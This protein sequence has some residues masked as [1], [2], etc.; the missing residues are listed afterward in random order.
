MLRK[1]RTAFSRGV[2]ALA[3]AVVVVASAVP[4]P[5]ADAQ[6]VYCTNCS[7]RVTQLLQHAQ[8]A[9]QIT[10]QVDQLRM[11][12][13][14]YDQMARDVVNLPDTV[15]SGI[16]Q[17]IGRVHSAIEQGR[18]LAYTVKNLDDQIASRYGSLD[19]YMRTDMSDGQM[20]SKYAQ[21]DAERADGVKATYRA[22]GLQ[23]EGMVDEQAFMDRLRQRSRT[24]QG[25][26]EVAT[27]GHEL[28]LEGIAQMQRLRQ[29]IMLQVGQQ[30][31]D[32]QLRQDLEAVS[33]ARDQQ[34]NTLPN[35]SYNAKTY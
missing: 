2:S 33:A 30:A 5:Q 29:L 16:V 17:D 19:T 22:L 14:T 11:Q 24:A 20:Q 25:Q 8:T 4:A 35:G 27:V 18:A 12:L 6:T 13:A 7:S 31:Q 21:W 34:F 32:S 9:R 1:S 26:R 15:M 10:L 3:L 28:A 23:A